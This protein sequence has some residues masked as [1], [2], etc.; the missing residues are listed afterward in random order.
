M[1]AVL[2]RP[3]QSVVKRFPSARARARMDDVPPQ[4]GGPDIK[5]SKVVLAAA[6]ELRREVAPTGPFSQPNKSGFVASSVAAEKNIALSGRSLGF[7]K[8]KHMRNLGHDLYG[9][10]VLRVMEA[11]RRRQLDMR[12]Q[13]L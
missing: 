10:C 2:M 9:R 4:W 6:R 12:G 1:L 8:P 13:R 7:K 5:E 3:V 11:R